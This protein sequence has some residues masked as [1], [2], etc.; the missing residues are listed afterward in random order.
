MPQSKSK[1]V[2][3]VWT[4]LFVNNTATSGESVNWRA[5]W[6]MFSG[7]S[8]AN[9]ARGLTQKRSVSLNPKALPVS[10][11]NKCPIKTA[12]CVENKV[13]VKNIATCLPD[14]TMASFSCKIDSMCYPILI[15]MIRT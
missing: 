12:P 2:N 6:K 13:N 9:V 10:Q 7:V 4:R 5:D 3:K 1:N 8:Y 14:I 11:A 15:L